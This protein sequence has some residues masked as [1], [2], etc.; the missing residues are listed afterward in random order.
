[1]F[2][3]LLAL[4]IV[5]LLGT[6][7]APDQAGWITLVGLGWLTGYFD[8]RKFSKSDQETDRVM[9]PDAHDPSDDKVTFES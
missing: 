4:L 6:G 3:A 7:N 9:P 1:M 2:L 8:C 5:V